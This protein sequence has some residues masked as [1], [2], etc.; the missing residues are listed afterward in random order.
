MELSELVDADATSIDQVASYLDG[1]DAQ[2][3]EREVLALDRKRQRKL[4]ELASAA[5]PLELSHFV[6]GDVER[7][8]QVRHRGRNTLPLPGKH[9]YFE[10]RFCL[11]HDGSER[12]FGYNEAPSKGML[13]PGYFVAHSTAQEPSWT[14]RG[15]V[16]VNYLRVPAPADSLPPQWPRLV[17]NTRGLQ[18]FVYHG[19]RDFMRRV[20]SHVSIGAAYK[21]EKALDHY[22]VLIREPSSRAL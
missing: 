14:P 11:P 19:T 21:G 12:L 8:Q 16:V 18:R 4:F 1:C 2:R 17:P 13:G 15:A 5:P 3:R 10:K 6:P 20:S 22:F 7:G 9:R